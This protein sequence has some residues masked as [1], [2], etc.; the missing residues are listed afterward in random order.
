MKAHDTRLCRSMSDHVLSYDFVSYSQ[1]PAADVA[2]R[3]S[4]ASLFADHAAA[5]MML[6]RE[7]HP[8][9]RARW[10]VAL[11][12]VCAELGCRIDAAQVKP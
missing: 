7:L 4:T 2:Q 6:C 9:E 5:S 3:M 12:A 1:E 11:E 10:E 8:H